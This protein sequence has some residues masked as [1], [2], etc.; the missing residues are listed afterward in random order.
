[1]IWL[2]REIARWLIAFHLYKPVFV[3]IKKRAE[4]SFSLITTRTLTK[5]YL[6]YS[7]IVSPPILLSQKKRK[8]KK[9]K[10]KRK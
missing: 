7:E 9:I 8:K 2:N 4:L 1:M 5:I 6:N 3:K 10:M